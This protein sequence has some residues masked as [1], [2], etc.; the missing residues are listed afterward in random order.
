MARHYSAPSRTHKFPDTLPALYVV[1]RH[2]FPQVDAFVECS[3][4]TYRL[5]LCR[6]ALP[7]RAALSTYLAV[8]PSLRAMF[9]GTRRT[10]PHGADLGHFDQTDAGWPDFMRVNPVIDWRYA[11]IWAVSS[12]VL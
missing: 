8:R 12:L 11:E 3:T 4:K 1:A 9:V 2:S 6:L 7:M 10:D 5:D